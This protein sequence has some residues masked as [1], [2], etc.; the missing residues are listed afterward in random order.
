[1]SKGASEA[2]MHPRTECPDIE[3][4]AEWRPA[5]RAPLLVLTTLIGLACAKPI[6]DTDGTSGQARGLNLGRWHSDQLHC[7]ATDC[8]DWYRVDLGSR[9]DL[10]IDVASP[11]GVA[12]DF[13]VSLASA[14]SE[15]LTRT[16][17]RGSGRA[18]LEWSTRAGTYLIEVSSADES[19]Q[20]QAYQIQ[21]DFT[22]EPPPPPPPEPQFRA[23]EAE[24]IEIEG[25]PARPDAVLVDKGSQSGVLRGLEGRL[26]D[27]GQEIGSIEIVEIYPEG[28]RAT[29]RGTL[30]A[31]VTPATR[32][33][34]DVPA[35]RLES[36]SEEP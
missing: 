6:P 4:N 5:L 25:S 26:Y 3:R 13:N 19:K 20:P 23:L 30:S 7:R 31:P 2:A 10:V 14:S 17:S 15:V 22:P 21:A 16:S 9:G 27:G 33:E 1:M 36:P 34:I 24:V 12:K 11:D 18:Q 28:S 8:S 32:A 35:E 29:I